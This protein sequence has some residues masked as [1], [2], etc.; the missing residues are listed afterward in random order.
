MKRRT[1]K[2]KQRL[3]KK[4]AREAANYAPPETQAMNREARKALRDLQY[5]SK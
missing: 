1:M 2:H 3:N 4:A 5:T